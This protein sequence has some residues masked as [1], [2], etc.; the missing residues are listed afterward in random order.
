MVFVAAGNEDV[1]ADD[2]VRFFDDGGESPR[3]VDSNLFENIDPLAYCLDSAIVHLLNGEEL[4][5]VRGFGQTEEERTPKRT[6]KE[7]SD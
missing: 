1:V 2:L 6:P 5:W 7:V 3:L 4:L